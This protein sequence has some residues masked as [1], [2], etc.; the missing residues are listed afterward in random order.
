LGEKYENLKGRINFKIRQ[1]IMKKIS[2][3]LFAILFTGILM[4]FLSSCAATKKGCGCVNK[5]GMVG[6]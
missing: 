6:Y 2:S 4:S 1:I 3:F 5:K